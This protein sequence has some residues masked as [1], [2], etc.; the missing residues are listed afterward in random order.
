M[1]ST[2]GLPCFGDY[3]D[4][5][6]AVFT[7]IRAQWTH[8]DTGRHYGILDLDWESGLGIGW[9]FIHFEG[10]SGRDLTTLADA[11]GK[12]GDTS[13]LT[14]LK[15]ESRCPI[16]P[17]VHPENRTMTNK[18]EHHI[19][20]FNK[21]NEKFAGEL[22]FKNKPTTETLRRIFE[23]Q[24]PFDPLFN[25]YP[26]DNAIAGKLRAL[27]EGEFDLEEHDYFLSCRIIN[28]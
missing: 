25:E 27:V 1:G 5:I 3:A 9:S 4:F 12:V 18:A 20:A 2:R 28:P 6:G 15:T 14:T 16:K 10:G 19:S 26:I 23:I 8:P 7:D 17:E 11:V 21:R 24:D 22:H 13:A